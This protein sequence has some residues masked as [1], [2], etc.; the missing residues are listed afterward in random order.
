MT[1]KIVQILGNLRAF[2][3]ANSCTKCDRSLNTHMF[4]TKEEMVEY[5]ELGCFVSVCLT[6]TRFNDLE[7][8]YAGLCYVGLPKENPCDPC[9]EDYLREISS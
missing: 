1:T 8:C 9:D 4:L 5:R 2:G 3:D 7:V 6:G